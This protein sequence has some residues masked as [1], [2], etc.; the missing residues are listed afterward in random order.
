M[1]L[2]Q[3]RLQ[4][5]NNKL[6]LACIPVLSERRGYVEISERNDAINHALVKQSIA[7]SNWEKQELLSHTIISIIQWSDLH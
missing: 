2:E 5:G 4:G 1:F 3:M 7:M 6:V